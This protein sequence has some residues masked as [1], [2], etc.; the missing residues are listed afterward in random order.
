MTDILTKKTSPKPTRLSHRITRKAARLNRRCF[1]CG[2]ENHKGLHL[3]FSPQGGAVVAEWIPDDQWES[4]QGIIHGGIVTAVLDEAMSQANI[5]S[6][7]EALTADLQIRFRK[8]VLPGERLIVRGWILKITKRII[9]T[10]AALTTTDGVEKAHA[11]ARF[12]IPS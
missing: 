4:F 6:G 7:Y 11:T 5:H 1:V 12:L 10:E 8:M 9:E 3:D 2:E